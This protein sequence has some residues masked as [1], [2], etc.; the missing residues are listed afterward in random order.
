[1]FQTT[2]HIDMFVG[3]FLSF[4]PW[5]EWTRSL[6][7]STKCRKAIKKFHFFTTTKKNGSNF[8]QVFW[9]ILFWSVIKRNFKLESVTLTSADM[10]RRHTVTCLL[11]NRVTGFS[12]SHVNFILMKFEKGASCSQFWFSLCCV[13]R[14]SLRLQTP[15]VV[16]WRLR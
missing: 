10:A 6:D 12:R 2:Y 14:A 15:A 16:C 8:R 13:S 9:N 3:Q 5:N 11:K 4:F 7:D 1:M